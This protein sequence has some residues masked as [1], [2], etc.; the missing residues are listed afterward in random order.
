[1]LSNHSIER[2]LIKVQLSIAM[3]D[4]KKNEEAVLALLGAFEFENGPCLETV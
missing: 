2:T 1:M 3:L 4:P